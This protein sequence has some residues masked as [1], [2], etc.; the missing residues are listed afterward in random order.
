MEGS[1]QNTDSEVGLAGEAE[2]DGNIP[3]REKSRSQKEEV[4]IHSVI[5]N[6]VNNWDWFHVEV[7]GGVKDIHSFI[8]CI[9]IRYFL[10]LKHCG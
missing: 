8:Q 2:E 4:V 7:Q 9:F 5:K 6:I 3:K 1:V 10:H